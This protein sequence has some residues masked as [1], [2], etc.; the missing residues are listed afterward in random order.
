MLS[1]PSG[2]VLQSAHITFTAA[3]TTGRTAVRVELPEPNGSTS[4]STSVRPWC[5]KW[6][7]SYGY[8]NSVSACSNSAGT[9]VLDLTGLT[10]ATEQKVAVWL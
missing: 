6:T 5:A 3:E 4:M 1:I 7:A 10:A 8:A 9:I 2:V